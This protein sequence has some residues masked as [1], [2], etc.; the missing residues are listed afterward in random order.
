M[1]TDELRHCVTNRKHRATSRHGIRIE[2]NIVVHEEGMTILHNMRRA[3]LIRQA[4][5]VVGKNTRWFLDLESK[6]IRK[7]KGKTLPLVAHR[8]IWRNCDILASVRMTEGDSRFTQPG[9]MIARHDQTTRPAQA[10]QRIRRQQIVSVE[11][12]ID[13]C[14]SGCHFF[15]GCGINVSP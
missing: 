7:G 10:G 1:C 2:G 3:G 12:E 6:K 15:N 11:A 13:D 5:T 9:E 8:C 14:S 4:A